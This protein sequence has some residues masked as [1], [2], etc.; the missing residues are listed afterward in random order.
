MAQWKVRPP[1][2]GNVTPVT[3]DASADIRNRIAA[4]ISSADAGRRKLE[5][6]EVK[7]LEKAAA[8]YK[9]WAVKNPL[10]NKRKNAI[11]NRGAITQVRPDSRRESA[12]RVTSSHTP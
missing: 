12:T 2:T 1:S 4:A 3:N 8:R 11:E 6:K 5:E 10:L 9:V 7:R